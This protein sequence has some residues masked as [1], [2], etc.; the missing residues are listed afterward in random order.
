MYDNS[1]DQLY[2]MPNIQAKI[3]A[4]RLEKKQERELKV[5][6]EEQ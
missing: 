4:E 1:W 5:K 3:N 2:V 6:A